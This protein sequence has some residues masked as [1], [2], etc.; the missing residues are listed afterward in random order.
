MSRNSIKITDNTEALKQT[1]SRLQ[2][3]RNNH[4][5][6]IE[7]IDD[8][9]I[10]VQKQIAELLGLPV[11]RMASK[12]ILKTKNRRGRNSGR[13]GTAIIIDILE[14]NNKEMRSGDLADQASALGVKSPHS[15]FQS[16]K[17]R[18]I[19]ELGQ[20]IVRLS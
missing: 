17:K 18:G 19:I 16:L 20:G 4:M 14:K 8:S 6:A 5:N 2:E 15:S 7:S 10:A 9:L 3:E 11:E 13:S 12:A 1:V